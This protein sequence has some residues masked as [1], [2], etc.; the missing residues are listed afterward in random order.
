MSK[1]SPAPIV[2]FA[3]IGRPG[4]STTQ[5][6]AH[7]DR[8]LRAALDHDLA[9]AP[10]QRGDALLPGCGAGETAQLL[11]VWQVQVDVLQQGQRLLPRLG[12]PAAR[13]PARVEDDG[14]AACAQTPGIVHRHARRELRQQVVPAQEDLRAGRD[15]VV[16]PIRHR[17]RHLLVR[18]EHGQDPALAPVAHEDD[19]ETGLVA[20]NRLHSRI[21]DPGDGQPA[22]QEVAIG[23]IPDGGDHE[24]RN[25]EPLGGQC[26]VAGGARQL[27]P[28][29]FD[30][31]LLVPRREP[32]DGGDDLVDVEVADDRERR[33]RLTG[34]RAPPP[35]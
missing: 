28:R 31:Q 10:A 19:A 7:R 29:R 24:R 27:Q 6:P 3:A 20:G 32:A 18:A 5:S 14:L 2:F 26:E 9:G 33:H 23:V 30:Q 8:A 12:R 1:T 21:V 35:G 22:P 4:H 15:P 16:V 11:L 13:I 17:H 34:H 25:A